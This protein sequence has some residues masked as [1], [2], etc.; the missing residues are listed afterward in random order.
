MHSINPSALPCPYPTS[1]ISCALLTLIRRL[2][3]LSAVDV[4]ERLKLFR[5]VAFMLQRDLMC[6]IASLAA[7]LPSDDWERAGSM[8][9]VFMAHRHVS[10]MYLR[11]DLSMGF[12]AAFLVSIIVFIALL[13]FFYMTLNVFRFV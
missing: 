3:I 13:L 12:A 6:S 10:Y 2:L 4:L 11:F 9:R 7:S 8:V 1:H 5:Q